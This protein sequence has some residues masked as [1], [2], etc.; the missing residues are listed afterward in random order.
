[1]SKHYWSNSKLYITHFLHR[2]KWNKYLTMY[3]YIYFFFLPFL[4]LTPFLLQHPPPENWT[5][6]GQSTSKPPATDILVDQSSPGKCPKS[7]LSKYSACSF[8]DVWTPT[9]VTECGFKQKDIVKGQRLTM[10][11]SRAA[12][13]TA[14]KAK[15]SQKP[16]DVQWS[17]RK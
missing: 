9:L 10:I 13:N 6:R 17:E 7:S 12:H 16:K 8:P 11:F 3:I 14:C 5:S 15:Q 2:M 4:V 1:M